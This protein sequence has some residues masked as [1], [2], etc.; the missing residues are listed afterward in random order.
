ML[1]TTLR[2][3]KAI[4]KTKKELVDYFD[5]SIQKFKE[6]YFYD[7]FIT[8]SDDIREL[9]TID[10]VEDWDDFKKDFEAIKICFNTGTYR[11]NCFS[12]EG[13]L[14]DDILEI[15][16]DIVKSNLDKF[17]LFDY[18][19]LLEDYT[20]EEIDETFLPINGGEFYT[21]NIATIEEI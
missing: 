4:F 17:N 14:Y 8:V 15:V 10:S 21:Y 11:M 3:G 19:E 18:N 2:N 12:A 16:E 20:N 1:K 5:E 7:G 9:F 13:T 6:D